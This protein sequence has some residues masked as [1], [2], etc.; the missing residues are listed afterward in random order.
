MSRH[1]SHQRYK[2]VPSVDGEDELE[3]EDIDLTDEQAHAVKAGHINL[4]S[5]PR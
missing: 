5:E 1:D 4:Q 2:A 3:K